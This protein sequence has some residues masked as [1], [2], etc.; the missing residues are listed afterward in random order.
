MTQVSMM[1]YSKSKNT[2]FAIYLHLK[3]NQQKATCVNGLWQLN[4]VQL[5]MTKRTKYWLISGGLMLI[6][7][8]LN[9]SLF[10]KFR[11]YWY[12]YCSCVT[13]C[14][15]SYYLSLKVIA[16][17]NSCK[18]TTFTYLSMKWYRCWLLN[19]FNHPLFPLYLYLY[20]CCYYF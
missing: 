10:T 1:T 20:L 14:F 4:Y 6:V 9:F 3:F 2:T 12:C 18:R 7:L 15:C 19:I 11:Y 8:I 13:I 5:W 16:R 17:F